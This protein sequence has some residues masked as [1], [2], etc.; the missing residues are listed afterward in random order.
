MGYILWWPSLKDTIIPTNDNGLGNNLDLGEIGRGTIASIKCQRAGRA[1]E[2]QDSKQFLPTFN[3]C[4]L[5]TYEV[6]ET[7]DTAVIKRQGSSSFHV[8]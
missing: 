2:N 8:I 3:K 7:G 1:V 6:P 4:L 5:G